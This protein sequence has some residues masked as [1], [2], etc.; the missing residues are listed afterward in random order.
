[1]V[2]SLRFLRS[3]LGAGLNLIGREHCKSW[4]G[5]FLGCWVLSSWSPFPHASTRGEWHPTVQPDFKESAHHFES[6][7]LQIHSIS[8]GTKS[9]GDWCKRFCTFYSYCYWAKLQAPHLGGRKISLFPVLLMDNKEIAQATLG[10]TGNSSSLSYG[11]SHPHR[12]TSLRKTVPSNLGGT[13]KVSFMNQRNHERPL[14]AVKRNNFWEGNS[15]MLAL[16]LQ[17]EE[18]TR[19]NMKAILQINPTQS[20]TG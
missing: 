15:Q 16:P 8:F 12:C 9:S 1:M 19:E 11:K 18:N 6:P 4:M 14:N 20:N 17:Q 2:C 3:L 7:L 5:L 10:R 13:I